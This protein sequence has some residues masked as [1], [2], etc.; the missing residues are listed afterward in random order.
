MMQNQFCYMFQ[1]RSHIL[2]VRAI[3]L[4]KQDFSGWFQKLIP[5]LSEL[6]LRWH[7][8]GEFGRYYQCSSES[9]M[10]MVSVVG[11]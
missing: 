5:T 2:I 8:E 3:P 1:N 4:L 6:K 11:E 9:S 7:W 10:A